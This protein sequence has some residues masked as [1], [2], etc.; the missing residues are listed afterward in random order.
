[1]GM[2]PEINLNKNKFLLQCLDYVKLVLFRYIS[3]WN[4]VSIKTCVCM[5]YILVQRGDF[6]MD[7]GKT[8]FKLVCLIRFSEDKISYQH[9]YLYYIYINFILL[10]QINNYGSILF[11]FLHYIP[12]KLFFFIKILIRLFV[13]RNHIVL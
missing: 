5:T 10:N 11:Y 8:D 2:R 4:D 12:Q 6:G 9:S 13:L 1:M 3:R 7:G